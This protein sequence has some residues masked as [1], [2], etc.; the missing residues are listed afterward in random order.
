MKLWKRGILALA[1]L[2]IVPLGVAVAVAVSYRG[3]SFA[4]V[5][6]QIASDP[7]PTTPKT[8]L[9][10]TQGRLQVLPHYEVRFSRFYEGRGHLPSPGSIINGDGL[11][12]LPRI[13]DLL[14]SAAYRTLHNREDLIRFGGP[15]LLH[16]NGA[17]LA[18]T[19]RITRDNPFTGGFAKGTNARVIVRTSVAL[20][21]T[22]RGA[23][24]AFGMALKMFFN[25]EDPTRPIA[26]TQKVETA[27]IFLVDNL[28]GT[29]EPYYTHARLTNRPVEP[30]PHSLREVRLL[31]AIGKA[32]RL[33]D[34]SPTRRQVYPISRLGV[35]GAHQAR[36]PYELLVWGGH[37]PKSDSPLRERDQNV[38]RADF[39]D[40]VRPSL[41]PDGHLYFNLYV[42]A[43][44][45]KT[46]L[47]IGYLD[48]DRYAA[49]VSCDQRLHFSHPWW[50]DA[51]G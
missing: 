15:K 30:R 37:D 26:E 32:L 6:K 46:W 14:S 50:L 34:K 16:P 42:R 23:K 28:N 35:S 48:L 39:R 24:R 33:N 29:R 51:L 19:W 22:D 49:S 17:C 7:Y 41:R 12:D 1:L 44:G 45:E 5:W 20:S 25:A 11:K 40:E 31:A 43:R 8:H 10:S 38:E 21:N 47:Y 36:T 2:S 9:L 18:G 27:N 3:S 13:V 4:E